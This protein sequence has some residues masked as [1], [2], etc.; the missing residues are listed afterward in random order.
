[1]NSWVPFVLV[2][3]GNV[4]YHLSQKGIPQ[5]LNPF[6]ALTAA[7]IASL[8][9]SAVLAAGGG[10]SPV[11]VA[12][13]SPA[14]WGVGIAALMIEAGYL[15]LYRTG[16]AVSTAP[17]LANS[18]VFL[19]LIPVGMFWFREKFTLEM[20]AGVVLCLAG[21]FLIVRGAGRG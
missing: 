15:L 9:L 4:V 18:C 2:V 10:V 7:Y 12:L 16:G 13:R 1:M 3:A 5:G 11:G 21:L 6:A 17:V 14:N 19:L 8:G 20:A